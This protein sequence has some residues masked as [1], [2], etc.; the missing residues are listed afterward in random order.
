M[1]SV[2]LRTARRAMRHAPRSLHWAPLAG[3]ALL[4]IWLLVCIAGPMFVAADPHHQELNIALTA[5]SPGDHPLGTDELGR[6]VL[7]RLVHGARTSLFLS[8]TAVLLAA[9]IGLVAGLASFWGRIPDEIVTRL[10]D[11]QLSIPSMLLALGVL[12]VVGS[13]VQSLLAVL[14][15]ASWVVYARVVRSQILYLR[16]ADFVLA[17]HAVG[18]RRLRIAVRH[19]VPNTVGVV[20]VVGSFEFGNM[21]LLE[22]ALGFLGLGLQAPATSWGTMLANARNYVS[23]AW[24]MGLFPGLAI[25]T[26][27]VAVNLLGDWTHR[28]LDPTLP[29]VR[30]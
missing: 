15:L 5:P 20:A 11:I 21:I 4:G 27:V 7:A 8:T 29:R 25:T 23:L 28:K 18:A 13:S 14:V 1:A 9:G 10:A 3:G 19:L 24:W 26:V 12:A 2:A 17:A 30:T 6:D 16:E 22:S